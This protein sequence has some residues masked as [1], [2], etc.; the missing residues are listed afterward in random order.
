MWEQNETGSEGES[1]EDIG[2]AIFGWFWRGGD[3]P[4]LAAWMVD[5]GD[6]M[7]VCGPDGPAAAEEVDLMIGVKPTGEMEGEV[8]VEET[9]AGARPHRVAFLSK[10]LGPSV[11][12]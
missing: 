8:E 12:G 9:R 6:R 1:A 7:T 3:D 4:E 11:V 5:N 10:S 2:P